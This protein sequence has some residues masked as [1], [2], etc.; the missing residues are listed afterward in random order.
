VGSGKGVS[1]RRR[2]FGR[3]AAL[4]LR[5]AITGSSGY[6]A[7]TLISRLGADPDCEFIL[8]LDI[9]PRAQRL[10]C[11]AVFVRFD[12]AMPWGELRDYFKSRDINTGVH[13]AWQFNP[14]HDVIRHRRID[15]E[16]SRNFLQ[17]AEAAGLKR[18]IYTSSTTAYVGPANPLHPPF[19]S[20]E[21]DLVGTSRYLYSRHKVEVERLMQNFSARHPE[22]QVIVLRPAIVLGPHTQNIVAKMLDWPWRSFPWMF[23]VGGSDPPMQFISEEDMGEVLYRAVRSDLRGVFNVAGEGT[24]RFTELVRAAGKKPLPIPAALLYSGTAIL[25]AL[26]L[27]PFPAGILDMIRYPWVADTTRLKNVFGYVPRHTSKEALEGLLA[28]RRAA[29]HS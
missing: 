8:G 14:I 9:K 10:N 22:I 23:K 5:V 3:R 17:A 7:Q 11:P 16:G 2:N 13:L 26:H 19:L 1:V 27:S 21:S 15:V 6:L 24:V 29:T 20:E 25:W 4:K 18:V 28:A 12:V